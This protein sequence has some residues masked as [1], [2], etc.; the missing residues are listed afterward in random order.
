MKLVG[1]LSRVGTMMV[2]GV[3]ET[4]YWV[5]TGRAE[6]EAIKHL[7]MFERVELVVIPREAVT[8]PDYVMS[9]GA[10]WWKFE[11]MMPPKFNS[12]IDLMNHVSGQITR[13]PD[14]GYHYSDK[15]LWSPI[16]A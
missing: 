15:D 14:G 9:N 13:H 11:T 12:P 16:N 6:I 10:K 8:P 7:P 5:T 1:I 2:S 4:G 3:E